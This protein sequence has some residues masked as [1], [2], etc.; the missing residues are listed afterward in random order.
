MQNEIEYLKAALKA[1][2]AEAGLYRGITFET[3]GY[4]RVDCKSN[5]YALRFVNEMRQRI[6]EQDPVY[7]VNK[8][9]MFGGGN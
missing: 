9:E 5:E 3:M 2:R 7:A 6:N 1:A 8:L 4:F